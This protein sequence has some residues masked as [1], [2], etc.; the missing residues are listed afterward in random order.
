M[1]S[2]IA[3]LAV[4]LSVITYVKCLDNGLARTP[5]MGW[6]SWARFGCTTDCKT[7]PDGCINEKLFLTMANL[8]AKEGFRELGYEYV[9]IDDC[10][11]AKTRN[12]K[13]ELQADPLRFPNGLPYLAKKIHE[14]GLKFGVYEDYGTKTC[15]GYPGI[16]GHLQKDAETIKSWGAD[17]LKLDGCNVKIS[18]MNK[19]YP[20]MGEYLNKTGRPILYS[21]SWPD[22]QR[23]TGMKFD[24]S[25]DILTLKTQHKSD[26][27]K[28]NMEY[29]LKLIMSITTKP[30]T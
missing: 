13:G 14:L 21:C 7:H 23:A 29:W 16:L 26:K 24:N 22:Y 27:K 3:L 6:I 10:Y 17:M 20:E 1:A 25:T 2:K 11:L 15:G 9:N 4:T 18:M 12:A 8:M 19:G 5:P 28:V 30:E